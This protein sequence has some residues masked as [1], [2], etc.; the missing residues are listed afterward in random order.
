MSQYETMKVSE[1]KEEMKNRNIPSRSKLAS[2]QVMMDVLKAHDENPETIDEFVKNLLTT[3]VSSEERTPKEQSGRS[4]YVVKIGSQ[5][6]VYTN[7]DK[8]VKA[9]KMFLESKDKKVAKEFKTLFEQVLE[10]GGIQMEEEVIEVE[11]MGVNGEI[12]LNASEEKEYVAVDD[13][14]EKVKKTIKKKKTSA[15]KDGP[16]KTVSKK[17]KDVNEEDKQNKSK[18]VMKKK[19][20]PLPELEEEESKEPL[21]EEI[22]VKEEPVDEETEAEEEEVIIK[23]ASLLKKGRKQIN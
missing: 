10:K 23:K 8:V 1:L 4:I 18:K 17:N 20:E 19:E 11:K 15:K 3:P 2:K 16:K 7:Q 6:F 9:V 21:E 13:L 12:Q 14:L 22:K 5:V